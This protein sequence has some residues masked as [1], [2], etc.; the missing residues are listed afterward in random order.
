MEKE[1]KLSGV[2]TKVIYRSNN[3]MVSLFKCEEGTITVTG[4]SFDIDEKS[5]YVLSGEYTHHPKYGFQF[6]INSIEKSIP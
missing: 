5:K 3:Y 2:F 4:P 6:K 1:E